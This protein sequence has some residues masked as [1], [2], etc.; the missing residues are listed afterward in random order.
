MYPPPAEL[1]TRVFTTLPESLKYRGEP[2]LWVQYTRPGSR[3]HSFL[4][5]PSFDR[6]GNLYCVD[7]PYGRIFTI[8]PD[9]DWTVVAQYDGE[10]N[11]LK[12]HKDGRIFLA[13][14]L[15][16][17]MVMDPENGKVDPFFRRPNLERFRGCNDL[18][19]SSNGDLYFTDPGRSS[20][21]D[22]TGRVFRLRANGELNLL[23]NNV[24][25]PNGLV[26]NVEETHLHV[27][28]TRGNCIWRFPVHTDEM[29]RMVGLFIQLSG[30][31]AGP[32]G[33]AMDEEGNLAIAHPQHGSV[34]LFS[35]YGEPLYRIR[36]C[37]G[38]TVTNLAYGG[39]DRKT[40]YITEA[41]TG[42][43]L[44]AQMKTPGRLMYS[45]M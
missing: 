22:P 42:S 8:S 24:P 7:V 4:E 21:N 44:T 37:T 1:E 34:W 20:L 14:H 27:A 35:K 15:H 31:L 9:G 30:G 26:M 18:F 6:A 41:D 5:G 38:R 23:L 2:N 45:H 13:D 25:Y 29:G 17:I 40:L 43:I 32:D 16:G 10:P 19:F 3:L 33:L 11:G 36:S 12:I 39:P 28:V